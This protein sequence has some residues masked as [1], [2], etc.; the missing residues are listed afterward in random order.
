MDAMADDEYDLGALLSRLLDA[1]IRRE[2][3]ILHAHG[4]TM[5]EYVIL[6]TLRRDSGVTQK[7]LARR[8]SRD[9]TRLIANLDALEARNLVVR[10]VDPSDR[11]RRTVRL[12][13]EGRTAVDA[14]HRDIREMEGT[15]LGALDSGEQS[16]LR[17]SLLTALR[18]I[19]AAED[20]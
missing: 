1:V 12:T 2:E 19:A 6:A 20:G 15:L 14:A 7:E 17:T 18:G 3:P 13:H 5:W 4:L 9:A 8:S 16:G 10:E 11:R